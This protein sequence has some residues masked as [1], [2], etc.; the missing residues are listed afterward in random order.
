MSTVIDEP[1]FHDAEH[2]VRFGFSICEMGTTPAPAYIKELVR[3]TA[4]RNRRTVGMSSLEWHAEGLLIRNRVQSAPLPLSAYG[5]ARYSWVPQHRKVAEELVFQHIAAELPTV[6]NKTLI[7]LL[8]R[9]Y[10]SQGRAD[11]QRRSEIAAQVGMHHSTV[12]DLD[13]R[14]CAHMDGLHFALFDRLAPQMVESGLIPA[15]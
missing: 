5:V 2:A 14:V 12:N 9:R 10:L 13:K 8:V 11:R 6:R 1:L 3:Q 7:L 15:D 4:K